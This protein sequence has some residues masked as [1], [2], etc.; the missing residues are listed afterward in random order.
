MIIE[1]L[2]TKAVV[3]IVEKALAPIANEHKAL[4]IAY[5]VVAGVNQVSVKELTDTITGF[6]KMRSRKITK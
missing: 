3:A 2:A 6:R 4:S 5:R 1:I